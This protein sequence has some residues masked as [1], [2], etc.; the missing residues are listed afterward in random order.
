MWFSDWLLW[1]Y[2]EHQVASSALPIISAQECHNS[3][4]FNWLIAMCIYYIKCIRFHLTVSTSVLVNAEYIMESLVFR[5]VSRRKNSLVLLVQKVRPL[6]LGKTLTGCCQLLK[7][8]CQ[9]SSW[10]WCHVL[11]SGTAHPLSSVVCEWGFPPLFPLV[12]LQVPVLAYW[13]PSWAS[14]SVPISFSLIF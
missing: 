3:Q 2:F 5:G 9:A 12:P 4:S 6:T 1:K 10:H 11:V 14:C 13:E 8:S 7:L